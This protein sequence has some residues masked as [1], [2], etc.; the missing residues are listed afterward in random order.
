VRAVAGP[1]VRYLLSVGRPVPN[2]LA[3]LCPANP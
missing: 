1:M 3:P 2:F